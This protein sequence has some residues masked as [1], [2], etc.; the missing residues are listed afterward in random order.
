MIAIGMAAPSFD[1]PMVYGFDPKINE[2]GGDI[3][4]VSWGLASDHTPP[5]FYYSKF[6]PKVR[7][8]QFVTPSE[9]EPMLKRIEALKGKGEPTEGLSVFEFDHRKSPLYWRHRDG[10]GQFIIVKDGMI[11]TYSE[12][13][14]LERTIVSILR[15]KYDSS[16]VLALKK[17]EDDQSKKFESLWQPVID[18]YTFRQISFMEFTN[19][20]SR[21]FSKLGSHQ[22]SYL[23]HNYLWIAE[24]R[25]MSDIQSILKIA[26]PN[27]ELMALE[28]SNDIAKH[29]GH[30]ECRPR[31]L[32]EFKLA[33]KDPQIGEG[34]EVCKQ[35]AEVA[36]NFYRKKDAVRLLKL[37][38]ESP[39]LKPRYAR[40]WR[41]S[42]AGDYDN[43]MWRATH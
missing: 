6:Y 32:E 14:D 36:I 10:M 30:F 9:T 20:I 18:P 13:K 19:R 38:I 35:L 27:D 29:E 33:I 25:P 1:G 8:A 22:T 34:P 31:V 12:E 5:F 42:Y 28:L 4:I 17:L 41:D 40:V 15:G 39:A 7:W 16:K 21:L 37:M 3:T 26:N 24:C 43:L 11:F 23:L 2:H